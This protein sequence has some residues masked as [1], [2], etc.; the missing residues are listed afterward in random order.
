VAGNLYYHRYTLRSAAPLNAR[1]SGTE[2]EGV[3]I[4]RDGG[5]GCIHPWKIFGDE[6]VDVQLSKLAAG[7]SSNLLKRALR[8]VEI[9]AAGRRSNR[10]LFEGLSVPESHA[11]IVGGMDAIAQAID[12]GFRTLKLK[13]GSDLKADAEK[14]NQV[15]KL[16]PRVSVRLDFNCSLRGEE[17]EQFLCV[18]SH[19]A[20]ASIEFLEDPCAYTEACWSAQRNVH[21]V[22]LA[23]DMGIEEVEAN[24]AF[25]V[26]KPARNRVDHLVSNAIKNTRRC[27]FTSYMDHPIGQAFAAFEA[28]RCEQQNPV[29]MA[30]AGL[31]THGLFE[32]N[33]FTE[34]L[35]TVQPQ[36]IYK[37]GTGL[38]FDEL[39][40]QLVWKKLN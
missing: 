15:I 16:F 27:V 11:T 20:R 35:G 7:R 6:S 33:A 14:V 34:Q 5:V 38:G 40:E 31:M 12:G 18:L 22:S 28:G 21:G 23:M 2:H 26:I 24:Y 8:C 3:L 1:T 4:F 29:C 32:P 19:D 39:I 9:D 37:E 25:S 13:A 30:T 36:W 17:L 10:S